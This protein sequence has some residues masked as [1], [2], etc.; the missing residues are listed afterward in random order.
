VSGL[1]FFLCECN[2]WACR[3]RL[4]LTAAEL[5]AIHR[6]Y[7]GVAHAIVVPEHVTE[8]ERG[9]LLEQGAGF[10]AVRDHDEPA[11]S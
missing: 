1:D 8:L 11:R 6:R 10:V 3:E 4:P 2:A 5:V 9:D 7:R